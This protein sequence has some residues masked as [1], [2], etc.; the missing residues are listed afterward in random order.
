MI[1]KSTEVFNTQKSL[2]T[3]VQCVDDIQQNYYTYTHVLV[4]V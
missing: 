2:L 3:L 1:F 4:K